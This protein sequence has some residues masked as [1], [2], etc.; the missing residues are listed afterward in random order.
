MHLRV[1]IM[2]FW[3]WSRSSRSN[4]S[5][6]ASLHS[7]GRVGASSGFG[8]I[9]RCIGRSGRLESTVVFLDHI[10]HLFLLLVLFAHGFL[11]F[12]CCEKSLTFLQ[13]I[14]RISA[15]IG[16]NVTC[17]HGKELKLLL[18]LLKNNCLMFGKVV[19]LSDRQLTHETF[20]SR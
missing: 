15:R 1:W 10:Q 9:H 17:Q 12:L 13:W 2:W 8:C 7:E 16:V 4:S 11:G 5:T 19:Y 20:P 3:R 14:R 6:L 18:V